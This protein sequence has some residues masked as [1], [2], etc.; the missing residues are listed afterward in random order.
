MKQYL[1]CIETNS[2]DYHGQ[3]VLKQRQYTLHACIVQ[4]K[5]AAYCTVQ[6]LLYSL[7]HMVTCAHIRIASVQNLF[8]HP[9]QPMGDL[10]F[11]EAL[12][13]ILIGPKPENLA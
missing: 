4:N 2:D 7:H 8:S 3:F 1:H 12:H 11:V 13:H 5:A 9:F 10:N 6:Y